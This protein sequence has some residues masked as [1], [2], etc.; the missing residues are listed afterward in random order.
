M[1]RVSCPKCGAYITFNEQAYPEGRVLIFTCPACKKQFR[2]RSKTSET[3]QQSIES[4]AKFIVVAN[5][6]HERQEL[7]LIPGENI[8]GR[9]VKGT[10]ATHP[11]ITSDP[12]ID[13]THCI[14]NVAPDKAGRLRYILRD[15]PSTTGTFY[16]DRILQDQDRINME[17]G[18]IITIGATT[19][20]FNIN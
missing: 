6:F 3:Q 5:T 20:I 10:N 15:A 12:S 8:I 19:L 2:V 11:I 16:Q 17:D 18:A 9:Y 13:T 1:K 4:P 7:N 14:V